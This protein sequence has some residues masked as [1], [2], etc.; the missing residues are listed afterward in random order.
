MHAARGCA[1]EGCSSVH[2]VSGHVGPGRR[3]GRHVSIRHGLRVLRGRTRLSNWGQLCRG[4][5]RRSVS[6]CRLGRFGWCAVLITVPLA[7]CGRCQ[8]AL[9]LQEIPRLDILLGQCS[10]AASG[11]A[12]TGA[13]LSSSAVTLPNYTSVTAKKLRVIVDSCSRRAGLVSSVP[14]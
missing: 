2:D 1:D 8:R 11:G 13:F 14:R 3:A 4:A 5:P 6:G 9:A 7:L 12:M 10:Q